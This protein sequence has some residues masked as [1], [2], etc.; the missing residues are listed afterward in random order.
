MRVWEKMCENHANA[1]NL[2]DLDTS[3]EF[4]IYSSLGCHGWQ[5]LPD[6]GLS[7]LILE[8]ALTCSTLKEQSV[9]L[10]LWEKIKQIVAADKRIV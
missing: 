1:W 2:T 7:I 5:R 8:A 10:A 4:N 3:Y 6:F 9:L